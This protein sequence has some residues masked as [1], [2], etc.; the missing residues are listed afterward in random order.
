MHEKF[1]KD[2]T[3]YRQLCNLSQNGQD[4]LDI[5][6]TFTVEI[7]FR[8]DSLQF[9]QYPVL[10][11]NNTDSSGFAIFNTGNKARP[12]EYYINIGGIGFPIQLKSNQWHYLT[13]VI[14]GQQVYAFD[15]GQMKAAVMFPSAY[16][17]SANKLYVGNNGSL[18]HFFGIINEVSISSG[19]I[20][21]QEV[22]NTWQKIDSWIQ[23]KPL[24]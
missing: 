15:N 24:P 5:P 18:R 11:A 13:V 7:L 9:Y 1:I 12:D 14:S 20:S 16:K 22:S 6:S 10:C 3:Y 19:A 4:S 2:S 23:K 21:A 17:K 8:A